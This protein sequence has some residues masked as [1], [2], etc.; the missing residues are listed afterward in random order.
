MD[1]EACTRFA[2]KVRDSACGL[3]ENLSSGKSLAMAISFRPMS[4]HDS[5]T[6]PDGLGA[7]PSAFFG[8]S[9]AR[10]GANAKHTAIHTKAN[11]EKRFIASLLMNVEAKAYY[12]P[13]D[14]PLPR[15]FHF[16]VGKR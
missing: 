3:Y 12:P 16:G 15:I 14:A 10:R 4:F 8:A 6:A 13:L 11:L 7:G 1:A 2:T 9:W 5:S